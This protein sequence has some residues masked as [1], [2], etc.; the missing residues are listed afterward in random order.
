MNI[1]ATL[2]ADH[3]RQRTLIDLLLKTH[4]DSRGR[5]ELLERLEREIKSHAAAEE[6][7]FYSQLI[8]DDL[9][10]DKVRHSIAEH[11]EVDE[12]LA[13]LKT[14]DKSSSGWL[15]T[16]EKLRDK[17]LHHLDEEEHQV[18][19]LAG[20]VLSNEQKTSMAPLYASYHEA[21]KQEFTS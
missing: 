10:Q 16:A 17:L 21:Q 11:E 5:T 18:F 2:R 14:T 20:K 4:G 7:H 19:Q 13:K 6:R 3:D 8:R 12:L 1:F 15:N 9:T